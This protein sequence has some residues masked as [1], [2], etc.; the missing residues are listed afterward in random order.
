MKA[1]EI[2]VIKVES[3]LKTMQEMNENEFFKY[4][5]LKEN[6]LRIN[7]TFLRK[8]GYDFTVTR[9]G[10]EITVTCTKRPSEK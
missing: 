5:A 4:S 10:A 2:E 1:K 9:R 8:K 7:A 6:T 3:I